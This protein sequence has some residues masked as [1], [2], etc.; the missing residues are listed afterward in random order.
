MPVSSDRIANWVEDA[1]RTRR[2]RNANQN[3]INKD[4]QQ[5]PCLFAGIVTRRVHGNN[6]GRLDNFFESHASSESSVRGRKSESSSAASVNRFVCTS[7]RSSDILAFSKQKLLPSR[8]E[9]QGHER[10]PLHLLIY[11]V[12]NVR[13]VLQ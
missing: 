12:R 11:V 8:V 6:K 13:K 5:M 4:K 3:I 2:T 10:V 7:S 1:G 9:P